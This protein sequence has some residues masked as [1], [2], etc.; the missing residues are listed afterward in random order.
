MSAQKGGYKHQVTVVEPVKEFYDTFDE[1]QI[2]N[3]INDLV[4]K[5]QIKVKYTYFDDGAEYWDDYYFNTPITK[6]LNELKPI[7]FDD[8]LY[9][10][11][12]S[13]SFNLIDIGPGNGYPIKDWVS[14]LCDIGILLNYIAVD[15]SED[16]N[17]IVQKNF[18]EWFPNLGFQ[19]YMKDIEYS[20]MSRIFIENKMG[21]SQ[22]LDS[23]A[24]V[25]VHFGNTICNHDDRIGVLKNISRGMDSND[26]LV[27]SYTTDSNKNK[28]LH[29]YASTSLGDKRHGLVA[30]LIGIDLDKCKVETTYSPEINARIK[31]LILDSDYEINF[32]FFGGIK[33]VAL[34]KGEKIHLW[35]HYLL[36]QEILLQELEEV[37]LEHLCLQFDK[38]RS[39]CVVICRIRD[40]YNQR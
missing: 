34:Q 23:I 3:I 31:Y 24:N 40:F 30:K 9:Y 29:K 18:S 14:G 1:G 21:Y 38:S 22:D 27:F 35:R 16:I 15:I 5:R 11:Q 12:E 32:K 10:L 20:E 6:S 8:I 19:K 2:I 33:K 7:L 13:K 17:S 25:V 4:F 39:N 37:G 28:I 26:L 36:A